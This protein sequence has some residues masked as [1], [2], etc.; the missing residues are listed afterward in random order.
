MQF[1]AAYFQKKSKNDKNTSL[2]KP[3]Y[4]FMGCANFIITH[5]IVIIYQKSSI[6][7]QVCTVI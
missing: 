5:K 1:Q 4:S 6:K 3:Y 2:L 7:F